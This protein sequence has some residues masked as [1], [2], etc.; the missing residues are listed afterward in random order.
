MNTTQMKFVLCTMALS[1][2]AGFFLAGCGSDSSD[3]NEEL[4][5][6]QSAGSE[7]TGTLSET[8][9]SG[10]QI[11]AFDGTWGAECMENRLFMVAEEDQPGGY[12]QRTLTID[13]SNSSYSELTLLYT[14]LQCTIED[15]DDATLAGSAG[16]IRF[17]GLITSNSGMVATVVR[18]FNNGS[19]PDLVGLLYRDGDVLYRDVSQSTLIENVVPVELSLSNP[20]RLIN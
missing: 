19:S 17:D 6:I 18:Y 2:I 5:E 20:W 10:S 7:T 14:D 3:S 12:V 11:T 8:T 9:G 16:D 4:T 15:P 1:H 13:S